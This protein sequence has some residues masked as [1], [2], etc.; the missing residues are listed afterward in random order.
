M[1]TA[2]SPPI[3]ADAPETGGVG[4]AVGGAKCEAQRELGFE[5]KS[6]AVEL[7]CN[8]DLTITKTHGDDRYDRLIIDLAANGQDIG[9]AGV[10][11]GVYQSWKHDGKKQLEPRPFWCD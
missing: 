8:A 10:S 3:L 7:T 11:V 4:A 1:P 5:V 2:S 6:W 9:K